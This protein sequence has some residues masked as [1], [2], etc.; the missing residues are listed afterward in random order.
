MVSFEYTSVCFVSLLYP[1]KKYSMPIELKHPEGHTCQLCKKK[2]DIRSLYP[3]ELV[4]PHVVEFIK[5]NFPEWDEKG[6]ICSTDLRRFRSEYI[7]SILKKELGETIGIEKKFVKSLKDHE[8]ISEDVHRTYESDISFGNKLSD[9]IASFGGSWKFII[10]FFIVLMVWIGVNSVALLKKPFDPFPFILMNLILS[11][12]AAIQAPIIM[13]SQNRQES[14]DRMR[15]ESDYKINL[16]AELEI[17]LLNEKIDFLLVKQWQ[18]LME[19][20]SVQTDLM[21]EILKEKK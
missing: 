10:I 21:E 6:Y 15:S 7:E 2:Y 13:M 8:L 5:L 4:R 11:C 1:K 14:K 3:A 19:I 12:L 16:K 9:K 18:R 20:Q 17:R